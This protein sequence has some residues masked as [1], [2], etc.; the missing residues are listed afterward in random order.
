MSTHISQKN[1]TNE[2]T[3]SITENDKEELVL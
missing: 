3:N 2:G 1:K